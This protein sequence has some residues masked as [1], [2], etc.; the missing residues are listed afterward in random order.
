[1]RLISGTKFL[2][3]VLN[4]VIA[5]T[6]IVLYLMTIML[7]GYVIVNVLRAYIGYW[8]VCT[9]ILGVGVGIYFAFDSKFT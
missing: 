3:I 6:L 9:S 1:M 7:V 8:I 2:Y 5:P 4:I